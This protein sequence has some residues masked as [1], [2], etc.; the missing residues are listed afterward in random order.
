MNSEYVCSSVNAAWFGSDM[1]STS[2]LADITVQH[3]VSSHHQL[4]CMMASHVV[5]S[6][7]TTISVQIISRRAPLRNFTRL[8]PKSSTC[9]GVSGRHLTVHVSIHKNLLGRRG[10]KLLGAC[11]SVNAELTFFLCVW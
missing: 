3:R 11:I 7:P 4:V 5:A 1:D 6:W 10:H 2:R 8:S 9:S